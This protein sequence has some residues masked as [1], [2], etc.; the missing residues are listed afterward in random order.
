MVARYCVTPR[1]IAYLA[2]NVTSSHLRFFTA[3][4]LN[5]WDVGWIFTLLCY[6]EMLVFLTC[7]CYR[8]LRLYVHEMIT[9]YCD[10][11]WRC[12]VDGTYVAKERA[13]CI[14]QAAPPPPIL[15]WSQEALPTRW[16]SYT[17]QHG[18]TAHKAVILRNIIFKKSSWGVNV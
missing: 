11:M 9:V 13:V 10:V 1:N 2:R 7:G 3:R 12:C 8:G 5:V 15:G 18:A 4:F 17:N 6:K 16:Y 14:F